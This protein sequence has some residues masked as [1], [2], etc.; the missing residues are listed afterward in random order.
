MANDDISGLKIERDKTAGFSRR[1]KRFF[2]L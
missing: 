2:M 1:K